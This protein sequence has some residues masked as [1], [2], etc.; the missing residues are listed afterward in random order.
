MKTDRLIVSLVILCICAVIIAG[1]WVSEA[2]SEWTIYECDDLPLNADPAWQNY[3]ST[4]EQSEI[5]KDPDNPGNN[6]LYIEDAPGFK[7]GYS[8]DWGADLSKGATL[9]V[10]MK[11]LEEG[12]EDANQINLYFHSADPGKCDLH[13]DRLHIGKGA[14]QDYELNGLEWHTYRLV[15]GGGLYK[16]YM[17]EEPEPVMEGDAG[18]AS[19]D[20]IWIGTASTTG[21]ERIYFDYVLWDVGGAYGPGDAPIPGH[22]VGGFAVDSRG[23][24]STTWAALKTI[25]E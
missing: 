10:R 15:F 8:M 17:D 18:A 23:K 21:S 7:S 24:Q 3:N 9:V 13:P 20:M 1:L 25:S 16:L 14:G 6:L 12:G 2:S 5:V 22:L 4:A 11:L 19:S